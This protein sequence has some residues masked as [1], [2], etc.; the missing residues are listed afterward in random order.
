[1]KKLLFGLFIS[2]VWLVNFS[3]AWQYTYTWHVWY[4]R[5]MTSIAFVSDF[6]L[7]RF[8]P[9]PSNSEDYRIYVD[10]TYYNW[11]W[12][13]DTSFPLG[14]FKS[15]MVSTVNV[16][17]D[18]FGSPGVSVSDM[19]YG[20]VS[21]SF[22]PYYSSW[23]WIPIYFYLYATGT[24]TKNMSYDY[25]CTFSWYNIISSC[26][27]CSPQ[28]TSSECQSEY[29]LVPSSDLSTCESSL[30]DC[31]TSLSG[32]DNTLNNCSNNL[33]SCQSSLSSCIQSNCPFDTWSVQWSALYINNIQ[34]LSSPIINID[35]PENINWDYSITWD[36]FD[37]Y[38][39]SGYDVEYIESII[40]INSYR[41]T[42][43]DF[44][45][46]FVGGLS[47]IMPYI[48]FVLFLVFMR[49]LIKRIF[50]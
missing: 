30:S 38:V 50:K 12:F 37:L 9:T 42:S 45:S 49:K 33:L 28:Y 31:Q 43:E 41:P 14:L 22:N 6:P 11:V 47:L 32:W 8:I 21:F 7:E 2:L 29:D 1:M 48:I 34:Y 35:I 5:N 40:D 36:T 44:T 23:K 13:D 39:G 26:P 10:C 24:L 19:S 27:I 46:V 3:I 17:T 4:T 20:H 15:I 25:S 18:D 16:W